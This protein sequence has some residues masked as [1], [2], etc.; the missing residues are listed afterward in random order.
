MSTLYSVG[1]MNQLG[2]A[3]EA[4]G[5]TPDEVTKLRSSLS[6]LVDFKLVLLGR[7]NVQTIEEHLIDCDA[8]PIIQFGLQ[9]EEHKK[10]GQ[11]FFDPTKVTLYL[12]KK[13]NGG[14]IIGND[15]RK[16]LCR[17]PVLNANVLDYLLKNPHLIPEEWKDKYVFFWGTVYRYSNGLLYVRYLYFRGGRWGWGCYWLDDDWH[18]RNP[19]AVAAAA[20]Y[21]ISLPT[22]CWESFV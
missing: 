17:K 15:L 22:S 6:L 1:Q 8:D 7:A 16:E 21:F 5:Y 14:H 13:Q 18:G 11:F 2:D 9:I 20:T 10:G 12:S 4:A 3:L 19:A